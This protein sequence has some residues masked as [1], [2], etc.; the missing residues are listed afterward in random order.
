MP[1]SWWRRTRAITSK[2]ASTSRSA[3]ARDP[4]APPAAVAS[5]ATQF[6]FAD[7]YVVGNAVSKGM[8]IRT[9]AG[10]YRRNPTA[11]VV[12]AQSD[13]KTPKDLE[14][15]TVAIATCWT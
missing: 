14:G 5:K 11:I 6:G 15:K 4:E 3:P 13:I 12:L 9:V 1:A 10:L 2:S 7:G 8:N